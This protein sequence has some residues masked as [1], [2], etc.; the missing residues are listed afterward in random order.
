VGYYIQVFAA[1]ALTPAVWFASMTLLEEHKSL[2][3]LFPL[4][5]KLRTDRPRGPAC[6]SSLK[7][8]SGILWFQKFENSGSFKTIRTRE[9]DDA[10]I[11]SLEVF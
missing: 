4:S 9:P 11:L 1:L 6:Q 8:T 10:H 7:K 5:G 2:A 3:L